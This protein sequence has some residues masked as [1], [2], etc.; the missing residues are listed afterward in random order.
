MKPFIEKAVQSAFGSYP[1]VARKRLLEL[2]ILIL[3]VA[4]ED[5]EGCNVVETLKWGEPSYLCPE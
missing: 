4:G 5:P 2:R 1:S 3:S